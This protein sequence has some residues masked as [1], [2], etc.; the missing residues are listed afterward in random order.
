MRQATQ[1]VQSRPPP[2]IDR[3]VVVAHGGQSCVGPSG[4]VDQQLEQFVLGGVGVLILVD[5]HMAHLRL[6]ALTHLGMVAQQLQGQA[7]Q[8]VK[9]HALVG[10][11]SLFVAGHDPREH[12]LLIVLRLRGCRSRVQPHV[13]PL[14]DRPLPLASGGGVGGAAGILEQ[15]EHVVAVQNAELR[16]EAHRCTVLAQQA[17]PQGV[18]GADQHLLRVPT[19]Q[20]LGALAHFSG[21]FVGE[22]DGGDSLRG[23]PRLNQAR[24]LVRD[25]PSFPRAGTCEHQTGAVQMVHR[26]VLGKIQTGRHALGRVHKQRGRS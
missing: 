15:A 25:H 4:L 19:H 17:H 13:F 24:D 1:V 26:F 21:G 11:Q 3:L 18:E 16:L 9:V 7:D 22:G 10:T 5:Q 23:Q 8:V 2:A 20:T 14:R 6:P 12:P